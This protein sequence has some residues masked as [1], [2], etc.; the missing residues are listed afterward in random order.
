MTRSQSKFILAFSVLFLSVT[1]VN[2]ECNSIFDNSP[3]IKITMASGKIFFAE[4][5]NSIVT[6]TSGDLITKTANGWFLLNAKKGNQFDNTF[7]WNDV[8]MKNHFFKENS[9]YSLKGKVIHLDGTEDESSITINTF[10][11]A[12]IKIK[13]CNIRAMKTEGIFK[14]NKIEIRTTRYIE[15]NT[16]AGLLYINT[17]QNGNLQYDFVINVD[18]IP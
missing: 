15:E 8:V 6:V 13:E 7:I 2:A 11:I 17:D 12:N 14:M 1:S 4:I 16:G 5:Q 18:S 10:D 3:K 9:S